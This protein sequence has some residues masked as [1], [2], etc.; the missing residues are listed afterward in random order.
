MDE[1]TIS[2]VNPPSMG[3]SS[4]GS[5]KGKIIVP[6]IVLLL[7][8]GLAFGGY[9]FFKSS[10]QEIPAP[11]PIPTEVPTP[12]IEATPTQEASPSPTKKVAA[13]SPTKKLTPTPTKTASSSATT[14][15]KNLTVRI[16]N[17]SGIA[18]RAASLSDYLKGLGYEIGGTGNADTDTLEKTTVYVKASKSNSLAALKADVAAKYEIGTASA[19]LAASETADAVVTIGKA[20]K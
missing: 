1:T 15:A 4:R 5:G 2:Q 6:I 11:T 13:P 3:S 7:L 16:L 17:G 20:T 19:T 10:Q 8:G 9:T 18:G 12:T 14:S